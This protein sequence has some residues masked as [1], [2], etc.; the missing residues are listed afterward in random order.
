MAPDMMAKIVA[1]W[2]E[3]AERLGTA[4]MEIL[5]TAEVTITPK[6]ALDEKV[7]ALTLLTRS[8]S[9]LKVLL[10]LLQARRIVEART[11]TR[12][13]LENFYWNVALS[14]QGETF[15]RQMLHDEM[16]HRKARGQF[17]FQSELELDATIERR[18][19]EWLKNANKQFP[20]AKSLNPKDVASVR[21]D[22]SKTYTI[23]SQLSSDA[24]HPSVHALNRYVVPHTEDVIGEIDVEPVVEDAEIA[25]TL[26]YFCMAFMGVCVGVNQMLDGTPGGNP[27][28]GLGDEYLALSN[29]TKA[30]SQSKLPA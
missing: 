12:C 27:L 7:L 23:Y 5:R 18:L 28:S 29:R 4:G 6:G 3:L 22:F 13:C 26:E 8:V 25:E 9:H 16:N 30:E 14:E 24:A 11:I 17:I 1:A 21:T 15:V 2:T 20:R 10:V 19:R